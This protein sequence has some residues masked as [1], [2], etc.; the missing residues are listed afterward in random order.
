MTQLVNMDKRWVKG[1][2]RWVAPGVV[3]RRADFAVDVIDTAIARAFIEAQHYSGSFPAERLS[4]GLFGPGAELVGVAVFSVP[5][6]QKVVPHWTGQRPND[7]AEL[8]RFVCTSAVAYNGESY[9]LARAFK[10]VRREKQVRAVVSY[11][12]PLERH[13]A[14][15]QLTKAAHWGTIYQASNALH[16]GRSDARTLLVAPSG[17]VVSGRAL[18][19]IRTEDQGW[20]YA[21]QQLLSQGA[22]ERQAHESLDAWV[23]RATAGFQRLLR[24]R[25]GRPGE[26]ATAGSPWPRAAVPEGR[27]T[28]GR[29]GTGR[30]ALAK[31]AHKHALRVHRCRLCGKPV[32]GN[33]G[34]AAHGKSCYK[35]H[36]VIWWSEVD[37]GWLTPSQREHQRQLEATKREELKAADLYLGAD[38]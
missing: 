26:K 21:A 17:R 1:T 13:N 2:E 38:T 3:F 16:V 10:L 8:G 37:R 19:K 23:R 29:D 35:R 11:A 14:A 12:D 5:M 32:R 36:G 34:M 31:G 27:M 20:Q 6:N 9:F 18:S 4:V 25:P 30:I 22:P 28:R 7:G 15:G 24:V 33:G